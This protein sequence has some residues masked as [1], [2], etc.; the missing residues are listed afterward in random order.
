MPNAAGAGVLVGIVSPP[1]IAGLFTI[2]RI[3]FEVKVL[4]TLFA[5]NGLSAFRSSTIE[6]LIFALISKG[7]LPIISH[8]SSLVNILIR[9]DSLNEGMIG[10]IGL[11]FKRPL[12]GAKKSYTII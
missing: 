3:S 10:S 5:T 6:L 2:P 7:F 8:I 4:N 11:I 9:V 12:T 1:L